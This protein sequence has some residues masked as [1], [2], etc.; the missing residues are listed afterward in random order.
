M[1]QVGA[2]VEDEAGLMRP[3]RTSSSSSGMYGVRGATPPLMPMFFQN[4]VLYSNCS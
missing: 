2:V 3:A 1:V 4:S